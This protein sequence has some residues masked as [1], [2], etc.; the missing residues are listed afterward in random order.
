MNEKERFNTIKKLI[1][2]FEEGAITS[3]DVVIKINKIST[4]KLDTYCL[5]NYWRAE[6]L[7]DL[8]KR[9]SVDPITDWK[10]IDDNK[11]LFLIKNTIENFSDDGI[12]RKNSEALEKRYQKP[13]GT[14]NQLI[15]YSNHNTPIEI[16]NE[17]KKDTVIR[18]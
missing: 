6:S 9:I 15:C 17:L 12:I 10:E 1:L 13:E 11:A 5:N 3:D 4:G 2:N 14:L 16:L 18:L 7:N 8:V